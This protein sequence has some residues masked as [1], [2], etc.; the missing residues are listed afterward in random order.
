MEFLPGYEGRGRFRIP[1]V[2][3]TAASPSA[4]KKVWGVE[5]TPERIAK[6]FE[7]ALESMRRGLCDGAVTYCLPKR[8]GDPVFGAVREVILKFRHMG[9]NRG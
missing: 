8:P 1:L 5:G 9:Q 2:V 3:M 4:F 7:M 6:K